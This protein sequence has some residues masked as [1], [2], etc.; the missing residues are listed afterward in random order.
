MMLSRLSFLAIA[1]AGL[2][3]AA[4]AQTGPVATTCKDDIAKYC[5]GK[6]HDG[7]V[8]ACLTAAKG[9]VSAACRTALDTTGPGKGK[10]K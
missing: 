8:R 2:A 1:S 4:S 3:A 7:E 10:A 5:A 9:K 6:T